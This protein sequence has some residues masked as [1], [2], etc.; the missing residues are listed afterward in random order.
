MG[1]W[2]AGAADGLVVPR[3]WGLLRSG[4]M[5]EDYVLWLIKNLPDGLT[6][7]YFH[8]SA[9]PSSAVVDGPQPTHQTITELQ[10][11]T[12]PRVREAIEKAE[13][14]LLSSGCP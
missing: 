9:D 3:T 2:V 12:S 7:L 6:E 1:L 14:E 10:T 4:R 13:V 8:P 5:T 11:L